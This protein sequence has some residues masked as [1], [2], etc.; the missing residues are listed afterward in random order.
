MKHLNT[1]LLLLAG[2][3]TCFGQQKRQ[4]QQLDSIFTM[5]YNQNQF[6]GTVLIAEK[7]KIIFK[8][9][10]GY[11][12]EITKQYNNVQTQYELASC[13]KQFTGAAIVLLKRAGKINY[14]DK[15]SKYIPELGFWDKVT[16]YDLLR[17]T[18]GIPEYFKMEQGWDKTKIATNK[19]VITYYTKEKDTL[20]FTPG[21][22]HRYTNTN[23]ILLASIIEKISGKTYAEFLSQ[24]IFKPLKMNNTFV[25]CSRLNPANIKNYATGYVWAKTRFNKVT[26]DSPEYD[27][28]SVRFFDG[29]VGASKI[30]SNVEDLYK[31]INALKNN[32]LFTQQEFNEM[33]AVTKTSTG[34]TIPYG[35][36]FDVSKRE[37]HFSFGH[38]GNWDGYI[39][40][41]YHNTIKD[42]TIIVLENFN[43][44]THPYENINE[45]IEGKSLTIEY[46]KKISIPEDSIAK[47]TGTYVNEKETKE[48]HI[49]T[50]QDGHLFYNTTRLKWDMRFF[51]VSANEFQAIRQGGVDGVL[52]F[53]K[54]ENGDTKLE[55]LEYGKV[56]GSGIRKN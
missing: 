25:Y 53:T 29:V 41:I 14:E 15:L 6:N 7:G 12:N 39:S 46:K 31:W 27:D 35:F 42:R 10:Y 2:T 4:E 55:M 16:I 44:G 9:G 24:H 13:S 54:L 18:S 50:C 21:S 11:S 49:I 5:M 51:P 34:K 8:K 45:I 33:T 23:Y 19:D 47:F 36:G 3:L 38:T 1:L 43:L 32:T 20:E 22:K 28:P 37:N 30:S 48:N 40:F 26:S 17:H 52:K 56:I